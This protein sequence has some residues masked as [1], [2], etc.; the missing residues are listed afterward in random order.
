MPPFETEYATRQGF[1]E[2][3]GSVMLS[4]CELGM[5]LGRRCVSLS[6][7]AKAPPGVRCC[8]PAV[9][10]AP[11]T[12]LQLCSLALSLAIVCC[13]S[14]HGLLCARQSQVTFGSRIKDIN[15]G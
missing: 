3:Q 5:Q 8:L 2:L 11:G 7:A 6:Q 1:D 14:M 13:I 15:G 10:T 12:I 9:S 4:P